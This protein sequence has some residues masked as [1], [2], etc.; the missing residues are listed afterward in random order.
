MST[1]NK[2]PEATDG[3][4]ELAE[5]LVRVINASLRV[6]IPNDLPNISFADNC[7]NT[8][9]KAIASHVAQRVAEAVA[10]EKGRR[11]MEAE[12]YAARA[13]N[14]SAPVDGEFV[15]ELMECQNDKEF[16]RCA[17]RFRLKIERSTAALEAENRRLR[18]LLTAA[19]K[20]VE[21]I[22]LR[23]NQLPASFMDNT[24]PAPLVKTIRKTL[25]PKEGNAP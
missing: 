12:S 16:T 23:Q 13:G 9:E 20:W 14:D 11:R 5:R 1:E 15:D 7:A 22:E 17:T 6:V 24:D 4:R 3:D 18:E 25:A 21:R 10:A 19:V 2:S 8:F